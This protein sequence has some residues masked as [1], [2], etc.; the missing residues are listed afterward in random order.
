LRGLLPILSGGGHFAQRGFAT[1][2]YHASSI[3]ESSEVIFDKIIA[4]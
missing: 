4:W 3:A 2:I 1:R